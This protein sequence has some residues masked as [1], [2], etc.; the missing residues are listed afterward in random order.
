[1]KRPYAQLMSFGRC[2]PP[3]VMTNYDFAKIG[4]DTTHEWVMERTGISRAPYRD[5]RGD[6]LQARRGRRA[7]RD[8]SRGHSGR[9]SGRDHPE[10]RHARPAPAVD[11]G[12]RPGRARRHPRRRLRPL[13]ACSGW[14]YALT[15]GEGLILA[16]S[17]ETVLVIA[18]E[19]LSSIVDW[20]DRSTCVLFGDGAGATVLKRRRRSAGSCRPTCEA[21]AP[22]RSCSIVPAAARASRAEQLLKD[23][24]SHLSRWP[25]ARCSSSG[26]LDGRRGRSRARRRKLTRS[27]TSTCSCRTRRT[28]GSSRRRPST[29]GI[30]MEKVYVNVDRYGNTS[31]ASIPV[32]LDERS[33]RGGAEGRLHRAARR[34]RRGLHVGFDGHPPL[35]A[36]RSHVHIVLLFPGQGSQKPG[37]GKDL[38]DAFPAARAV[39]ES[40]D[41]ALAMPLSTL[42]F[43]GPEEDL[44]ATQNAQPAIARA[45]RRR[46]GGDAGA[47]AAPRA[48]GGGTFAGRVHARTTRPAPSALADAL[49]VV[50]RRGELMAESG[51]KT[52]GTMAAVL[53]LRGRRSRPLAPRR[54]PRQEASWCPR[55]TT[56]RSRS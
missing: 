6:H 4:I 1:M 46:V 44:T 43:E 56:R 51:A 31:S 23:R 42:C 41:K 17:A 26:A 37:M 21:T 48:R 11:R 18:S 54:R 45:R 33:N 39:F 38:A 3:K 2:V 9:R 53:G 49:R 30:P 29:R 13:A 20:T 16:G 35:S 55:T 12:G 19:K 10:H 34:V 15:V 5:R 24:S 22:S 50:R 14:L 52:P 36:S 8:G 28:S 47:A 7:D 27:R 40:A 25:G 32:A